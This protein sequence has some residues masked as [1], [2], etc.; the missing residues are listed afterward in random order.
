M[1]LSGWAGCFTELLAAAGAWDCYVMSTPIPVL[2]EEVE[3]EVEEE[4]VVVKRAPRRKSFHTENSGAL[5]RSQS[6]ACSSRAIA[7]HKFQP[8]SAPSP[9]LAA[10]ERSQ[11]TSCSSRALS[12]HNST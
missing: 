5:E 4:E 3:E 1:V 2:Q 11:S 7:V 6:T 9:Q 8:Q 12:V 10:L